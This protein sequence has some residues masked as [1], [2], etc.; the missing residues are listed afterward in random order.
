MR[1]PQ[2]VTV[3]CLFF[4]ANGCVTT[5]KQSVPDWARADIERICRDRHPSKVARV[6]TELKRQKML[7]AAKKRYCQGAP[8]T[9]ASLCFTETL[10][11]REVIA[12]ERKLESERQAEKKFKVCLKSMGPRVEKLKKL[13][14]KKSV[15]TGK[16]NTPLIVLLI[17]SGIAIA[18]SIVF[19][20]IFASG[21]GK[22]CCKH[23]GP[24]SKPCG[25]SC[26]SLNK[27]CHVGPG[28]AC[29]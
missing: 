10:S 22:T 29:Y 18:A 12:L 17:L 7:I 8:S 5:T 4:F 11:P 15:S 19:V 21:S 23:C 28:C 6:A 24:G 3:I 20:V 9:R 25:N 27:S 2:A 1:W 13:H 14:G 16:S 26:I